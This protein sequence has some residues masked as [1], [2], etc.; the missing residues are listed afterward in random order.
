MTTQNK[1]TLTA[2]FVQG[3]IPTGTNYANFIDSYVN[4]VET[5]V[6][7]M[8]GPLSCT[9][10]I[11]PRISANNVTF[12]GVNFT[13]DIASNTTINT[14]ANFSVSA[15]N[16]LVLNTANGDSISVGGSFLITS[17]GNMNL[18][19]DNGSNINVSANSF[20]LNCETALASGAFVRQTPV[21]ISAAGTAQATG[22]LLTSV[23]NRG[24]GVVDGATTGFRLLAN[25]AGLTQYIYN[26]SVSANL[27]PPTGGSINALGA[28]TVFPLAANT[29]YTILHLTASAYAVK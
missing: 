11:T 3:A 19:A 8:A 16:G 18:T 9:E 5:S 13:I 10:L 29:M 23:I 20:N 2:I 7:A 21:I 22:A 28:N 26:D 15:G 6:Q 25:K 4:V 14:G 17:H 27:W 1:A 24:K 12:G